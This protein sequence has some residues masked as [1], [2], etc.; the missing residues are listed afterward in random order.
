MGV[1]LIR[2]TV[3]TTKAR[4]LHTLQE[5]AS[6][7][8]G[9]ELV[10]GDAELRLWP[11]GLQVRDVTLRRHS[12]G[13]QLAHL[14]QA[15]VPLTWDQG[16]IAAGRVRVQGLSVEIPLNED[17][18]LAALQD[19]DLPEGS[20]EPLSRLPIEGVILDDVS[21]TVRQ[22]QRSATLA[23]DHLDPRGALRGTLSFD[24][25]DAHREL[26]LFGQLEVNRRGVLWEEVKLTD[27]G[28]ALA[29]T[30]SWWPMEGVEA[31]SSLQADLQW[32]DDLLGPRLRG[33]VSVDHDLSPGEPPLQAI[34][35]QADD[36]WLHVFSERADREISYQFGDLQAE[37]LVEGSTLRLQPT[38]WQWGD[39]TVSLQGEVDLEAG[40]VV[41]STVI[42]QSLSLHRIFEQV[43][44][45]DD[46]WIDFLADAEVHLTGPLDDLEL[47][48]P[49]E[50]ALIDLT[51]TSGPLNAP[52][53]DE[54]LTLPWAILQGILDL[55]TS[56]I[57]L[58]VDRFTTPR[59]SGA[60]VATLPFRPEGPL[61]VDIDMRHLD[62]SELR[63][64]AGARLEG[65]G[66]LTGRL[67]GPYARLSAHATG[68]FRDFGALGFPWADEMQANLHWTGLKNLDL[69][70]L[71]ARKGVTVYG[72]DFG[73][74]FTDALPLRMDVTVDEGRLEDM[75]GI[76]TDALP[77]EGWGAA[78]I[79][80]EGPWDAM[81]GGA[82]LRLGDV[83]IGPESFTEGRAR[84]IMKKGRMYFQEGW[85]RR[86]PSGETVTVTG[87]AGPAWALDLDVQTTGFTLEGL[88]TLQDVPLNL[89]ADI[90]ANTH[91][92][93]TLFEPE[94]EGSARL[95]STR[96]GVQDLP[97]S[98]A[99]WRTDAD[100]IHLDAT[101]LD[102]RLS[103]DAVLPLDDE[104]EPRMLVSAQDFPTHLL[105]PRA[106]DDRPLTATLSGSMT[107]AGTQTGPS[108]QMRLDDA[109][110]R[111]GTMGLRLN[112][113]WTLWGTP[114]R[115][116]SGEL[117]L[118]GSETFIRAEL[119]RGSSGLY[120]KAQGD[121]TLSWLPMVVPGV[122]RADGN[123]RFRAETVGRGAELAPEIQLEVSDGLLAHSALPLELTDLTASALASPEGYLLESAEAR[124]G[125][126]LVSAGG[127]AWATGFVPDRLDLDV[128]VQDTSVRWVDFLPTAFGDATLSLRGP[129]DNLL[130]SGLVQVQDM[131]FTDRIDWE[132]SV[133]DFRGDVA[134]QSDVGDEEGLFDFDI[135]IVAPETILLDNNVAEGVAS[136]D[137]RL[138]GDT[139]RMGMTGDVVVRPGSLAFLQDR[140]FFIERGRI[141][142][143]DPWSWDPVL[144]F[145]LSTT[146]QGRDAQYDITYEVRGVY[147]NWTT[148]A[149]SDPALPQGDIN[150]LLWLGATP[151]ELLEEGDTTALA[152]A[153]AGN[154]AELF[155]SDLFATAG[156]TG[157]RGVSQP[158]DR[159]EFV[160]G[161]TL[162][163][164]WTTDPRLRLSKRFRRL[165]DV[166]LKAE[167][168][169][170]SGDDQIVL[171]ERRF[172]NIWRIAAWWASFQRVRDRGDVGAFGLDLSF[173]LEAR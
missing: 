147:S 5:Q 52:G 132:R 46:P 39:G 130:L 61:V 22:P 101:V 173:T 107:L 165:G 2:P 109:D 161:R 71:K 167:F 166:E 131:A 92:G 138:I 83:S 27:Q 102:K 57:T 94:P 21:L 112:A 85:L 7:M 110:L 65:T 139:A 108:L 124:F 149:S 153:I 66:R 45:S 30:G 97:D 171:L 163:N 74:T 103:V 157:A 81:S 79:Q 62:L 140:T 115:W 40:R 116:D 10:V 72:G 95:T 91:V 69:T 168:S 104:T 42:A 31:T 18:S 47:T 123:L 56:Q 77:I 169:L 87:T 135:A 73:M 134:Q 98:A 6:D 4:Y 70:E 50:L 44:T 122:T 1:A 17:G 146:V 19:L 126:G 75:L 145:D 152:S 120:V 48:G 119:E 36:L 142:F 118:S 114:E 162:R 154:L 89:V 170:V 60:V 141:E 155:L 63:P 136:A 86:D 9:E 54:V 38:T 23:I 82:E 25:G 128:S 148:F 43:D 51:T 133:L 88:Q 13:L 96:W 106:A 3:T 158:I 151:E 8:L 33:S 113:P 64:L 28:V 90:E 100:G 117:L 32:F 11:P 29:S 35:L 99:T 14:E 58:D 125:G 164:D 49:F 144:D 24:Q 41:R 129:L 159:I 20:G 15:R 76:F 121:T 172:S 127:T 26:D 68:D 84:G 37:A 53:S 111:W 12:D 16:R 156:L 80:L 137:L 34:Q 67:S 93:G 105:L 78:R 160:S 150:A 143:R 55:Q 59:S